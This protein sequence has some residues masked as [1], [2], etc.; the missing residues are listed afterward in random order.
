MDKCAFDLGNKCHAVTDKVCL[1]C[2]FRKTKEELKAG[3]EK[4]TKRLMTLDR[5]LLNDINRKYY[6]GRSRFEDAGRE[7]S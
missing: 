1:G 6:R 2:K 5:T 3:R 4:A 7:E